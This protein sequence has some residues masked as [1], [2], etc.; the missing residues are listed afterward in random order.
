MSE[1]NKIKCPDDV[2]VIDIK[3]I[4]TKTIKKQAMYLQEEAYLNIRE[5]LKSQSSKISDKKEKYQKIQDCRSHNTIFV[6]GQRGSGKTQ[7]IL[8]IENNL[9]KYEKK[10]LNKFHFFNPIDPT[11]LHENES[12][13]TIIIAK[14]LNNL[15]QSGELKKQKDEEKKSFYRI[16]SSLA[17]AIDGVV[18]NQN[19]AKTSLEYISQD[20][21]S[22]ML[23]QYLHLFFSMVTQIVGKNRLIL[24]IDDVDMAFDKGFEVLEV[25]RKYLSSP[26]IIPIVTGHYDLYEYIVTHEL[27]KKND[28]YRFMKDDLKSKSIFDNEKYR[29]LISSTSKDYLIK[30]F[31]QD[32]RIKIKSIIEIAEDYNICFKYDDKNIFNLYYK[33]YKDFKRDKE[34]INNKDLIKNDSFFKIGKEVYE[35]NISAKEFVEKLFSNR[36]RILLQYLHGEYYKSTNFSIKNLNCIN[37]MELKYSIDL[38][39]DVFSIIISKGKD[40]LANNNIDIAINYFNEALSE[41]T[42]NKKEESIA[43]IYLGNCH[44]AKGNDEKAIIEYKKAIKVD[45]ENDNAYLNIANTYAKLEDFQK[46]LEF[47][48]KA[49][50]LNMNN[51]N[52]YINYGY[53][54][55]NLNNNNNAIKMYK[56]AINLNS[57]NALTHNNIANSYCNTGQYNNALQSSERALSIKPNYDLAY[58]NKGIALE[59]LGKIELS[60]EAY[61]NS[62]KINPDNIDLYNTLLE[63]NKKLHKDNIVDAYLDSLEFHLISKG[64]LSI[65]DI[66]KVFI[67]NYSNNKEAMKV[68]EMLELLSNNE[69]NI[70]DKIVN[71]ENKFEAVPFDWEFK[72]LKDWAETHENKEKLLEYIDMF[73]EHI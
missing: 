14:V 56:E 10:L 4:D 26:Y 51:E 40:E 59:N 15:E 29:E 3:N 47:I 17:E 61:E 50:E 44:R 9:K 67:D 43:Y 73:A 58:Y 33:Q 6:N 46:A 62:L 36:L 39:I 57:N 65:S 28:M 7:F 30:I 31:P 12:F 48:D 22:L 71:W 55:E 35:I 34:F 37:D 38:T 23:E 27:A 25:I 18:Q 70:Y 53:I 20:Q 32:K 63:M 64:Q 42:K 16:L 66:D 68:Y 21:T 52:T 45:S 41:Y 60:I 49:L 8:S 69:E 19:S 24:L 1:E 13:L 54:E 2:I 72:E 5:I 11:L